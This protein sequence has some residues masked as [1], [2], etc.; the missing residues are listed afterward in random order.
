MYSTL[1]K[2]IWE[3]FHIWKIIYKFAMLKTMERKPNFNVLYSESTLNFLQSLDIKAR[4]KILF[5]IDKCR[6][7]LDSELFKKLHDSEIWEFRTSYRGV[8]YRIM[9]FWDVDSNALVLTTHGFI[10]KTQKTP[11]KEIEKA[12]RM[13]EEYMNNKIQKK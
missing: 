7:V 1:E 12:I 11:G 8:S 9:A 3:Y 5:N 6:Y 4:A 10:K 2:S 13:R